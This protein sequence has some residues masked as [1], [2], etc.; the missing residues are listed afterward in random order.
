MKYKTII[1][2]MTLGLAGVVSSGA[3]ASQG[4]LHTFAEGQITSQALP[5]NSVHDSLPK[6]VWVSNN[7]VVAFAGPSWNQAGIWRADQANTIQ[8]IENVSGFG[9]LSADGE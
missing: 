5:D 1:S 3:Q 8:R 6:M 2:A 4:T 9:G 7:G